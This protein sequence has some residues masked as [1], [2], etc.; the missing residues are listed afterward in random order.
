METTQ[1]ETRIPY[2]IPIPQ[3]SI[4]PSQTSVVLDSSFP[5]HHNIIV[6]ISNLPSQVSTPEIHKENQQVEKKMN[7]STDDSKISFTVSFGDDKGLYAKLVTGGTCGYQRNS[8]SSA[9]AGGMYQTQFH[10]SS[11]VEPPCSDGTC[12]KTPNTPLNTYLQPPVAQDKPHNQTNAVLDGSSPQHNN[13]I[14]SIL[15]LPSKVPTPEIDIKPTSGEKGL[16]KPFDNSKISFTVSSGDDKSFSTDSASS[17]TKTLTPVTPETHHIGVPSKQNDQKH[18][19]RIVYVS[20]P[21][22][23]LYNLKRLSQKTSI[24]V[25]TQT[26]SG[27]SYATSGTVGS[28]NAENIFPTYIG[29]VVGFN[30]IHEVPKDIVPF[31]ES[32][33]LFELEQTQTVIQPDSNIKNM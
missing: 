22:G 18:D 5:Q 33:H 3:L 4:L 32:S 12:T 6:P 27:K 25:G 7:R 20:N 30:R 31:K 13:G 19:V 26:F 17:Y 2:R 16:Q 14:V 28:T 23:S 9:S 11:G 8:K 1:Y 24:V 10:T 15:N 21:I 29:Q